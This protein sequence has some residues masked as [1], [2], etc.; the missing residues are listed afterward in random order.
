MIDDMRTLV[1]IWFRMIA[2]AVMSDDDGSACHAVG[3]TVCQFDFIPYESKQAQIP[4]NLLLRL[5]K[6]LL[7]SINA[8]KVFV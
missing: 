3:L 5:N 4:F 1:I 8:V 7:R 2:G 6:F